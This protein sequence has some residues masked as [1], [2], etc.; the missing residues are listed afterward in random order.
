MNC[1]KEKARLIIWSYQYKA[2][3]VRKSRTG[4]L[5]PVFV[6]LLSLLIVST[7][8]CCNHGF[9]CF[10]LFSFLFSLLPKHKNWKITCFNI[11]LENIKMI[12]ETVIFFFFKTVSHC[13]PLVSLD[14]YGD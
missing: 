3:R 4:L 7:D 12:I 10:V 8:L 1:Y 2:G 11:T 6:P 14:L 9:F 5:G 13:V